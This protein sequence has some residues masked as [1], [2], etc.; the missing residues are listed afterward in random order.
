MTLVLRGAGAGL[1][2]AVSWIGYDRAT[3]Y[4]MRSFGIATWE[5]EFLEGSLVRLRNACAFGLRHFSAPEL[6]AFNGSDAPV[7][8][9]LRGRVFDVSSSETFRSSYGHFAGR[10]ATLALARM[11]LDPALALAGECDEA[12]LTQPERESL[13]SWEAYFEQKYTIVGELTYDSDGTG[14][15]SEPAAVPVVSPSDG[16]APLQAEAQV[17][18]FVYGCDWCGFTRS[19]ISELRAALAEEPNGAAALH[20]V[21]CDKVDSA[22]CQALP[23]YPFTVVHAS[24]GATPSPRQLLRRTAPGKRDAQEVVREW[25]CAARDAAGQ[26]D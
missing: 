18:I 16:T 6:S 5:P 26:N 4:P 11:S 20:V 13:D 25:R 10:D 2:G 7:Y 22:V 17:G 1:F 9:A 12:K 8:F 14:A 3:C 15:R 24:S 19:Q 21:E 23:G